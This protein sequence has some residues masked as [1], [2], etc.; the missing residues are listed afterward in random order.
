MRKK[1]EIQRVG[2]PSD[3]SLVLNCLKCH[4]PIVWA[5]DDSFEEQLGVGC[6]FNASPDPGGSVVLWYAVDGHGIPVSSTQWFRVPTPE[7]GYTG[8]LWSR[9]P[10]ERGR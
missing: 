6:M 10:C 5:L 3:R 2:L 4:R 1:K 7:V 9:H 8:P